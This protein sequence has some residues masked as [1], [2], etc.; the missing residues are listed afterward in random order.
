MTTGTGAALP[1]RGK[2]WLAVDQGIYS[3]STLVVSLAFARS[4]S[5]SD[6]GLFSLGVVSIT[7]LV[8]LVRTSVFE[9]L[10]IRSRALS[11]Q[12]SLGPMLRRCLLISA[13]VGLV[14]GCGGWL[15]IKL[16][17][18]A[19]VNPL[20]ILLIP[21]AF[22]QDAA[23]MA[24]LCLARP[25]TL[26]VLDS[27]ALA[28]QVL[29]LGLVAAYWSVA[30]QGALAMWTG[31]S[32]LVGAAVLLFISRSL[33]GV[34]EARY[35][36]ALK[37]GRQFG[38]DYLF[39]VATSQLI[40]WTASFSGG[41]EA[42]AALRGADALMGPVRVLLL[43]APALLLASLG[44]RVT[45]GLAIRPSLSRAGLAT[46]GVACVWCLALVIPFS[47]IGNFLLGDSWRAVQEVLPYIA[48]SYL[49]VVLTTFATVGMKALRD[50]RS[51]VRSRL[52]IA[53]VGVVLGLWGS[54]Q[55]EARGAAVATLTTSALA[56]CVWMCMFQRSNSRHGRAE[57][58][59]Q[60]VGA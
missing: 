18:S 54:L 27:T 17:A 52:V 32:L 55:F 26:V 2:A 13:A 30:F 19:S 10:L 43:A 47:Y 9:P 40:L 11:S 39:G 8:G 7:L 44:A 28:A 45:E 23:R 21:G 58:P 15:L 29:V 37:E 33:Q 20:I 1:T 6:F 36:L 3:L 50:G 34:Q 16:L 59:V 12:G 48:G 35:R 42:A 53:P 14:V 4:A 25:K 51:L 41:P 49:F 46:L 57:R 38:I 24:L 5:I 56:A 31:C 60:E 22:I